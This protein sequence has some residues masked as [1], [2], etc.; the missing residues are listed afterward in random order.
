[1]GN[2]ASFDD[3]IK[4]AYHCFQMSED[5]SR[6]FKKH[7]RTYLEDQNCLG[8][9]RDACNEQRTFIRYKVEA[10]FTYAMKHFHDKPRPREL[11]EIFNMYPT[12]LSFLPK[13]ALSCKVKL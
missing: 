6:Q 13:C 5:L 9:A 1:M 4:R 8:N 2:T 11:T 10:D 7:M 3:Q 12:L